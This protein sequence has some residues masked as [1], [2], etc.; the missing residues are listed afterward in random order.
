MWRTGGGIVLNRRSRSK[1]DRCDGPPAT[2]GGAGRSEAESRPKA[3]GRRSA[4]PKAELEAGSA[5]LG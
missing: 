4:E 2:Q 3:W 5:S 1:L